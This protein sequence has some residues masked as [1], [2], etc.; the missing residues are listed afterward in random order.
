M[1]GSHAPK[2]WQTETGNKKRKGK[3]KRD[4]NGAMSNVGIA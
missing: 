4:G 1:P 2:K 3:G